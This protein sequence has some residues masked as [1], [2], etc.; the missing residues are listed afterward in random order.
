MTLF[1]LFGKKDMLDKDISGLDI[2]KDN[3]MQNA[4]KELSLEQ[5]E[6]GEDIGM[7]QQQI[8]AKPADMFS[9]KGMTAPPSEAALR[10]QYQ[11]AQ[12]TYD[13]RQQLETI[14]AKLDTLR[15]MI[16]NLSQRLQVIE[17]IAKESNY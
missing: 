2:G 15:A 7:S 16:E 8:M 10:Q 14:S 3:L 11:Q 9:P 12:Q 13:Y 17:R 5:M 1:G 6:I 4:E